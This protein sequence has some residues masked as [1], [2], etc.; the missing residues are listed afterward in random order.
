M[1][2]PLVIIT[3]GSS[4][5]GKSLANKCIEHKLD[6]CLI[7]RRKNIL[8]KVKE[9][10][11]RMYINPEIFILDG[12]ISDESF[13]NKLFAF[14]EEKNYY[15]KWLINC[16]G[17]GKFCKPEATSR[18]MIDTVFEANLV[19]L[20]LMCSKA[21]R[22][23]ALYECYIINIMSTAALRGKANETVY[24]AAKW[25]ARGYTEA[26]KIAFKGTKVHVIGVYPGGMN[27]NFWNDHQY[28]E[29]QLKKYLDSE[30]VA[31]EIFERI[32]IEK[33][34]TDKDIIIERKKDD[35]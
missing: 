24:C 19:G 25:G 18:K 11:K 29:F 6:V 14:L 20:I 15:P 9:E 27:T 1:K 22:Y 16:A 33:D 32:F 34:E 21:L 35:R 31:Q 30:E 3:G 4:G 8:E 17:I 5:L 28:D 12:N 10:F 26:L 23:M 2:K 7:A 13:V